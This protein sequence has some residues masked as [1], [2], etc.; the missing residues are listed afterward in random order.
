MADN[1]DIRYS[2]PS[3]THENGC[4]CSLSAIGIH[5]ATS[6]FS[7]TSYQKDKTLQ[8]LDVGAKIQASVEVL[9]GRVSI[10]PDLDGEKE[11]IRLGLGKDSNC[12]EIDPPFRHCSY[13][14]NIELG[15]VDSIIRFALKKADYEHLKE[16]YDNGVD[17]DNGKYDWN[18]FE[19][20]VWTEKK[21]FTLQSLVLRRDSMYVWALGTTNGFPHVVS[22]M[23]KMYPR[24]LPNAILKQVRNPNLPDKTREALIHVNR[25][26]DMMYRAMKISG[27]RT[28]D[29][30]LDMKRYREIYLAASD[31]LKSG[32]IESHL[33]DNGVS[34]K[35]TPNGKKIEQFE[36]NYNQLIW[37]LRNDIRPEV[38]FNYQPKNET[39]IDFTK[40]YDVDKW[41][42]FQEKLRIFVIPSGIFNLMEN[43]ISKVRMMLETGWVIQIRHKWP[44]GGYD[45]LAKCLGIKFGLNEWAKIIC[46]GDYKA[47]D[48]TIKELLTNLYFSM[49]LIHERKGTPEYEVKEKILRWVIEAQS[50][51]IE[52]MFADLFV[53]HEGGVPSGMY[54]TSHCDS[55]VTALLFFLFAAWSIFN[56]PADQ[57]P[58]LERIALILL[59]FI[60]YGDDLLYNMSDTKLGQTYFN[61]YRFSSF[62][63]DYFDMDLR[64]H[65]N[66]I[67]FMSKVYNGWLSTTGSSF[68]RH[69]AVENPSKEPGQSISLPFRESREVIPRLIW[70]R[71]VKARDPIDIMMSCIG[72]AWGTYGA[73]KDCYDRIKLFFLHLTMAYKQDYNA[74]LAER[75]SKLSNE[76]LRKMRVMGVTPEEVARG[77]PTWEAICA[78][79]IVDPAY[80]DIALD[81]IYNDDRNDEYGIFI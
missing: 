72:H 58:E 71:E 53:R 52:R 36:A 51:R 2:N 6:G 17:N 3:C 37:C 10:K 32:K 1:F 27:F 11:Y 44:R 63:K 56:A 75:V 67:S 35:I 69:Y 57:R 4:D 19:R 77:F 70:G 54:N 80:Q 48:V 49:S 18:Y 7:Y 65:K 14:E 81:D 13:P 41:I 64:D 26:L 79:N 9:D 47:L 24:K 78:H 28:Q 23:S 30:K 29:C 31:G 34:L 42:A 39:Y 73:N 76:S 50:V 43:L 60:C 5:P 38:I 40:Q 25:A 20:E 16:R 22:A 66:G 21:E 62:L 15:D 61:I 68:L 46:E 45:R 12:A 74:L 59:F 8:L 33:L 55:W